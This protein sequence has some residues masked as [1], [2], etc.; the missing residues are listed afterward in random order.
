M[1][2]KNTSLR[3]LFETLAEGFTAD[4][5]VLAGMKGLISAAI[6]EKRHS[7]GL[8]Q[9][10]FA[11]LMEVSQSLVSRWES[12]EENFTLETL[13]RIAQR[14]SIEMQSPFKEKSIVRHINMSNVI[15]FPGEW[16]GNSYKNSSNFEAKEM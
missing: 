5:I 1:T 4:E 12:G 8:S 16:H 9:K 10:K 15:H 3:E 14:L 11:E 2:N 7:L 13:V 6:A